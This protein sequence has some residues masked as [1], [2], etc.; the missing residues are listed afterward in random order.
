MSTSA[1]VVIY[2]VFDKLGNKVGKFIQHLL[3]KPN[4]ERFDAFTPPEDFKVETSWDDEDEVT[5]TYPRK[6]LKEF[7]AAANRKCKTQ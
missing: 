6:S 5:H 4:W 2:R 3:C 7:L 1:N